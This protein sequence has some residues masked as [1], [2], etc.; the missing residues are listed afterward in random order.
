IMSFNFRRTRDYRLHWFVQLYTSLVQRMD[1]ITR[2][3]L[4]YHITSSPIQLGLAAAMRGIP[5]FLFGIVAGALADR[6]GRKAQLIVAQV[7]NAVLNLILATL[8]LMNR[9]QPWHVY[10]TGFLVGTVQA[11]QNP[12]RQ[13]LVSDIAGPRHLINALALNSMALNS[14]RAVGPAF[15]GLLIAT[16]GVH[17]SY[18]VQGFM[19]PLATV[20]TIQMR[21]PERG[22]ESVRV[23]Q[24]SL[25]QSIKGGFVY[26]RANGNIRT[27]LILA[28]G[29]LTLGMPFTNMM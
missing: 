28:L 6:S 2:G 9:V 20:L 3:Y 1:S 22:P 16:V 10:V 14:S 15:A 17:G 23:A 19:F 26:V 21:I 5:L 24:E 25:F 27:Q 18:Y 7:T 29:P 4:I 13:T 8:V 11:F 12:A